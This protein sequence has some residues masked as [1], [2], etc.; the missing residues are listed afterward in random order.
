[1]LVAATS[2]R[3][4]DQAR[5]RAILVGAVVKKETTTTRGRRRMGERLSYDRRF[6]SR[7]KNPSSHAHL[8]GRVPFTSDYG[9]I[10]RHPPKHN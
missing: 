3:G 4:F 1:L 8:S 2:D 9:Q 10:K 5:R 7:R 6:G